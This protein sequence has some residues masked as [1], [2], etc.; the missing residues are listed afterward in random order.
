[1][2]SIKRFTEEVLALPH[3]SRVLLIEQLNES[4]DVD[5]IVKSEWIKLIQLSSETYPQSPRAP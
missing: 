4:I 3:D 2:G 1:M 5:P